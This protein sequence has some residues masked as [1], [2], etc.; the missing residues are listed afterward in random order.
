MDR[1]VYTS[2][3]VEAFAANQV[4]VKVNAEDRGDGQR[5]AQEMGVHAYP[6]LFIFSN[7][8]QLIGQQTGAFR[9][10]DDFLAWLASATHN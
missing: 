5:F 7:D 2:P 10:P 8:G 9:R 3:K 4:F 1:D 6:S